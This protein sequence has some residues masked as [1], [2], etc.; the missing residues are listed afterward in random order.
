MTGC[1]CRKAKDY[2]LIAGLERKTSGK[3]AALLMAGPTEL[4]TEVIADG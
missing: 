3:T 1:D 4:C 2:E